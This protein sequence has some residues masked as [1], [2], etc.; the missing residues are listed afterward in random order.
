M[1]YINYVFLLYY[2]NKLKSMYKIDFFQIELFN[3]VKIA[4]EIILIAKTHEVNMIYLHG[5]LGMGKTTLSK[6]LIAILCNISVDAVNSP[7]FTIVNNYKGQD[8]MINHFDL[9]RLNNTAELINIGIED[10]VV[11]SLNIIEWPELA[12]Q[13]NLS[14]K[15]LEVFLKCSTNDTRDIKII[16]N[17]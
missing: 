8:C 10:L 16:L 11:N 6:N 7:T 12:K 9:Y 5:D 3:M 13:L 1:E 14:K 15:Y 2:L 17:D 4:Q